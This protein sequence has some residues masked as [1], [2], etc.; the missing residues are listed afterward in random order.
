MCKCVVSF[1]T[2]T[3]TWLLPSSLLDHFPHLSVVVG[4]G[5]ELIWLP[6]NGIYLLCVCVSFVFF[7][8][9]PVAHGGSQ[10]GGRIGVLATSLRH[11][12]SNT[13]S[14]PHLWPTPPLMARWIL[15]LLSRA[16]ERTCILRDAS[17]IVFT[18]PWQGLHGRHLLSETVRIYINTNTYR[19][20]RLFAA[21]S[22]YCSD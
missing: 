12:H 11:S 22:W 8:T 17:Q 18:K 3:Y 10:A 5:K 19:I 16:G 1:Q 21:F 7:M 20:F 15:N 6:I 4:R 14:K 9:E 2:W 13:T